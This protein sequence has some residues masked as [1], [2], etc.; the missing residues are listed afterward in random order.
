MNLLMVRLH[1]SSLGGVA[2]R[3][4]RSKEVPGSWEEAR[5]SSEL[6]G[7]G[8]QAYEKGLLGWIFISRW[9]HI[10][11]SPSGTPEGDSIYVATLVAT[12]GPSPSACFSRSGFC[13]RLHS[14]NL[15]GV[16]RRQARSS[17]RL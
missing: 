12:W 14:S 10:D 9:R 5:G 15:R 2:R 7:G 3:R 4:A 16:A 13:V 1:S 17:R 6:R 11:A 8:L